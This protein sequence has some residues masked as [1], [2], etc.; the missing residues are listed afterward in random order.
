MASCAAIP[1]D[2]LVHI[3]KSEMISK[4]TMF[5]LIKLSYTSKAMSCVLEDEM[6]ML[7]TPHSYAYHT[8]ANIMFHFQKLRSE[9]EFLK[10]EAAF[11]FNIY[12]DR[13]IAICLPKVGEG[14]LFIRFMDENRQVVYRDTYMD[15]AKL[16]PLL[17]RWMNWSHEAKNLIFDM[18][19]KLR[20]SNHMV[21]KLRDEDNREARI[22]GI[23][24]L[25]MKIFPNVMGRVFTREGY[26]GSDL[27]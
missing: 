9:T 11:C 23:Q 18:P 10:N 21:F 20:P 3:I 4:L 24:L 25:P 5:D 12:P 26:F 8:L 2:D 1:F 27:F 15:E 16:M 13:N 7:K 19:L 22:R 17:K 6:S 14:E